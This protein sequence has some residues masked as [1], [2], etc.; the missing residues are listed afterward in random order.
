MSSKI[1]W[2]L[3]NDPIWINVA[4]A[5]GTEKRKIALELY[6]YCVEK[7]KTE[8]GIKSVVV[9]IPGNVGRFIAQM[10]DLEQEQ[11]AQLDQAISLFEEYRQRI[12]HDNKE[13]LA[14][15]LEA[16]VKWNLDDQSQSGTA[17][18]QYKNAEVERLVN[19]FEYEQGIRQ[20]LRQILRKIRHY[21]SYTF[22]AEIIISGNPG[23][24]P[25]AILNFFLL[26]PREVRMEV[27][28]KINR[29][30]DVVTRHDS[31]E[32]RRVKRDY[33]IFQGKEER[34]TDPS[35][36]LVRYPGHFVPV[37]IVETKLEDAIT[38]M[39]RHLEAT[40]SAQLDRKKQRRELISL[41]EQDRRQTP[42]GRFSIL[43]L[44]GG[45]FDKFYGSVNAAILRR[46]TEKGH[47]DIFLGC[48]RQVSLD[49]ALIRWNFLEERMSDVRHKLQFEGKLPRENTSEFLGIL[50]EVIYLMQIHDHWR[51]NKRLEEV[52]NDRSRFPLEVRELISRALTFLKYVTTASQYILL[53]RC[54]PREDIIIDWGLSK[55]EIMEGISRA[56]KNNYFGIEIL[57]SIADI[58]DRELSKNKEV[59]RELLSHFDEQEFV[60][61]ILIGSAGEDLDQ[62][63]NL[64]SMVW[65]VLKSKPHGWFDDLIEADLSIDDFASIVNGV[66]GPNGPRGTDR[67]FQKEIL[68]LP[69]EDVTSFSSVLRSEIRNS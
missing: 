56:A 2:E 12:E 64:R 24:F 44:K 41:F 20:N 57:P 18:A 38:R 61:L 29:A 42:Q 26:R 25:N 48:T 7:A 4:G 67:E 5:R 11:E 28:N 17:I 32:E 16:S 15:I 23:H 39:Q 66:H 6:Q 60:K 3:P 19:L 34:E 51:L 46:L 27:L 14:E 35:A 36:R 21:L 40:V 1:N 65:N 8:W 55:D 43:L 47:F 53:K 10:V 50:D 9:F 22:N 49:H 58:D 13:A 33:E 37:S 31:N 68:L 52:N 45:G 59:L 30:E 63:R 62:G 54:S 69:S